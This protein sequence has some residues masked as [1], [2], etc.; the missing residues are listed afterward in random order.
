[1]RIILKLTLLLTILIGGP[2][3]NAQIWPFAPML[4]FG[5]TVYYNI[6]SLS[7][8]KLSG[9]NIAFDKKLANRFF[10]VNLKKDSLG[11]VINDSL[12]YFSHRNRIE[13]KCYQ[14]LLFYSK[15]NLKNLNYEIKYLKLI[16][17][18]DSSIITKA[19]IHKRYDDIQN[20]EEIFK[21]KKSDISG[22][23]LGPGKNERRFITS[24]AIAGSF[25]C[26]I[27]MILK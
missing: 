1:M 24:M 27:I 23:F 8:K 3:L 22:V 9:T 2:K 12:V 18:N 5:N 19:T 4:R 11:I 13:P 20:T 17:S 25:A 16:D 14:E 26:L 7:D 15:R 21:I 10:D 6:D